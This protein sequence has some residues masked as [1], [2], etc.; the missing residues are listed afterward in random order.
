MTTLC[1]NAS[2][3][4]LL[5]IITINFG[6]FQPRK[7]YWHNLQKYLT[8]LPFNS[9][10]KTIQWQLDNSLYARFHNHLAYCPL[11]HICPNT[12][13]S[14]K[15]I[16]GHKFETL[17]AIVDNTAL[18]KKIWNTWL[19]SVIIFYVFLATESKSE[20]SFAP[21]RLDFAACEVTIFGKQ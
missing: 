2:Y 8:H 18:Q 20:I 7:T 19:I 3:S 5:P 10:T 9:Q 13:Y 11:N 4:A 21:S 12:W 16:E 17:F 15:S 1:Q 14:Q 6:R